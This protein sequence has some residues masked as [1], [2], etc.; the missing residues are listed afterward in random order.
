MHPQTSPPPQLVACGLR[1]RGD[2]E[3]EPMLLTLG[4]ISNST[5]KN[6]LETFHT[7]FYG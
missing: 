4:L 2:Q 1:L 5:H 6:N 7:N 3:L